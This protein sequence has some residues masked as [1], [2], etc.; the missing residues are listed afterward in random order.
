MQCLRAMGDLERQSPGWRG[1]HYDE[2]G[3]ERRIDVCHLGDGMEPGLHSSQVIPRKVNP[4]AS[5]SCKALRPLQSET[6]EVI[7]FTSNDGVSLQNEAL[8]GEDLLSPPNLQMIIREDTETLTR[9]SHRFAWLVVL[10]MLQSLS[11]FILKH[12]ESIFLQHSIVVFFLTMLVGAGGNAGSQSTV[13][14]IR[15]IAKGSF[16]PRSSVADFVLNE[17]AT[18]FK[19]AVILAGVSFVRVWLFDGNIWE[20]VAICVSMF[21]IVFVAVLIG[22][23]LPLSLWYLGFDAAHAGAAIQVTIDIVGVTIT[24][25]VSSVVFGFVS[26]AFSPPATAGSMLTPPFI[27]TS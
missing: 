10:L 23:L 24:C 14:A 18:G 17:I 1:T 26:Q 4:R 2:V 20:V 27:A 21:G 22:T 19:L 7:Q 6:I 12:F 8:S 3:L 16:A 25:V 5:S 13:L 15:G 11:S 9:F